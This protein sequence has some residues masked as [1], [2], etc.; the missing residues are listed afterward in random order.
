MQPTVRLD[1]CSSRGQ[2][3]TGWSTNRIKPSRSFGPSSPWSMHRVSARRP[4]E[5][6]GRKA[7]L[8]RRVQD[9]EQ[10]LGVSLLVRTTRSMRLT[11]E[12]S[13][14]FE[15]ASRALAAARDAEAVVLSQKP[16]RV[17]SYA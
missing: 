16:I 13:A 17:G 6:H 7:T 3:G 8:S 4:R 12:G 11:E 1:N 5:T 10:R 2:T 14:Y 9:L 15:H